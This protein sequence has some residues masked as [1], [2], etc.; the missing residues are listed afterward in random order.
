V[1][2]GCGGGAGGGGG[3]DTGGGGGGGGGSDS[4]GG[5]GA[6]VEGAL[7][8]LDPGC[9]IPVT[10]TYAPTAVGDIY[11]ALIVESVRAPQTEEEADRGELP[12]FLEDPV[13]WK[14]IVYLHG[15]AERKQGA[16][17]VRPR[18]YDFGYVHPDAAEEEE[19]AR[20]ELANLGNGDITL[21]DLY[22]SSSCGSEFSIVTGYTPGTVLPEETSTLVEV[23]YT[24]TSTDA[25]YCQLVITSDDPANAE[26]DV[27]LTANAGSDPE[28]VPPTVYIRQPDNG[29][30]YSA[31]RPLRM[32]LN[33]FDVNQPATSLVCKVKSAVLGEVSIAN[34]AASDESGHVFIDIP[35]ENFT[36]G[37]DTLFVT[38][39]DG[40]QTSAYASVSVLVNSDY[41]A[42]DD[43][44]D[45]YG[46]TGEFIDCDDSN[47]LSYPEAAEL[48][49]G[50][51]N[52]C[53]NVADEGTEGSDDDGDAYTEVDGDCNDFSDDVY[54]GAPE[55][56]D[57][58]D[59]D[60]DGKVDEGTSLS[61]DDGDGFAEVNNDCN[62]NDPNV[63][64]TAPEV[65][66]GVDNDCDGLR[67]SADGCVSVD[68]EP[69]IIGAAVRP[70]QNAC[71][72]GDVVTIDTRAFDADGDA[73]TYAWS[74]D[75]SNTF[76][77]PAAPV[78]N[79]TCPEVPSNV[80]RSKCNIYALVGDGVT[81]TW[82]VEPVIVYPNGHGLYEPYTRVVIEERSCS[83]TGGSPVGS[84]GYVLGR[85]R[86]GP[87]AA[88]GAVDARGRRPAGRARSR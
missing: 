83:T 68:S 54:P 61:D 19:P 48:Y 75:C 10:V 52:D 51:D 62:D 86:G 41:P 46:L 23:A 58:L 88:P 42:D 81:Q 14:Q 87:A 6:A 78:V 24:P 35:A 39:T 60:C 13:H 7:F 85:R 33:I 56:G 2:T 67:D 17:L 36:T 30:R 8:V 21:T 9:R 37:T 3:T 49:D 50:Q 31:I 84:A 27:T 74:D 26:V 70:D 28:N 40:S 82:A 43:D 63:G 47:I 76:D 5:G 69:T 34:C 71:E 64:P 57:A 53:D 25:A 80:S 15:E 77:N 32:E 66:D 22:L 4:G 44:G 1:A 20:I 73:L 72:E 65:C 79:W 29:Y 59:N 45:G 16:L 12:V 11:G 38:V 55:R 18:S